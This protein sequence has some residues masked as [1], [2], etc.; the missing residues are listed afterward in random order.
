MVTLRLPRMYF[1]PAW[2]IFIALMIPRAQMVIVENDATPPS[3]VSTIIEAGHSRFPVVGENKDEVIGILLAKD[4]LL[5]ASTDLK[6]FTMRNLIRPAVFIPESK[7]LNVLLEEFR[8][9]R[10]HIA[11]VV[12]E[13]G[14]VSGM[15]T[16]E[17]VLEQIVGEIEDEYDIEE[18]DTDIKKLSDTQYTLKGLVSIEDFNRE[19]TSQCSDAE[20]DTIGGLVTHAFGHVPAR[21]ETVVIEN[22]QFKVLHADK[23]RIHLLRVTRPKPNTTQKT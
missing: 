22:L 18:D 11:I 6:Q 13:Y 19:F 2:P 23:R 15:V 12:D 9:K 17:D 5:Y 20:F 14:S 10:N 7:R 1:L 8:L 16:I 21:G 3:I 4:L